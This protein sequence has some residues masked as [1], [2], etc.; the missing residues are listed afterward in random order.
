ME[1]RERLHIV[2]SRKNRILATKKRFICGVEQNIQK[3]DSSDKT[4][5][6]LQSHEEQR[7]GRN[8]WVIFSRTQYGVIHFQPSVRWEMQHLL[9]DTH[10]RS[11]ILEKNRLIYPSSILILPCPTAIWPV[12]HNLSLKHTHAHT[13]TQFL[14][15]DRCRIAIYLHKNI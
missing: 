13:H 2:Q 10:P 3:T 15:K 1:H 6:T 5:H 7:L 8:L 12:G 4:G 14:K 11:R 9:K